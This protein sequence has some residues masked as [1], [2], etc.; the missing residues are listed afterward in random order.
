M[1]KI[2][3]DEFES[4]PIRGKGRSGHVFNTIINLQPGEAV[5]IEKKDWSR[6]ASPSSLVRYIE[7]TQRMKFDFG[8]V[9]GGEGWAVRRVDSGEQPVAA[10][11]ESNATDK[12]KIDLQAQLVI[13]YMG[14]MSIYKIERME[15][16]M[17]ACVQHF[18]RSDPQQI[19]N[20][21]NDVIKTLAE[22]G[23]IVIENEK[24]Y[25]PLRRS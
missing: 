17:K 21:F 1:K 2:S 22:Q 11:A 6:K 4:L 9:H 7:K 24:A 19:Q 3:Q 13:F 16:S 25:I 23:H 8:A 5:L 14:R 20:I 18:W 10:Q 15:D 12:E